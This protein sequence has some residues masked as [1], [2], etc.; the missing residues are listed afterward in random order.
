[1]TK[2]KDWGITY[3][4]TSYTRMGTKTDEEHK[5]GSVCPHFITEWLKTK[6]KKK[7]IVQELEKS[8]TIT[9][10]EGINNFFFFSHENRSWQCVP[11]VS[12]DLA[13]Q[14][15]FIAV[16]FLE[17]FAI[18]I[19]FKVQLFFKFVEKTKICTYENKIF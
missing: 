17:L 5:P 1:M 8:S 3:S 10:C 4:S 7:N 14:H 19:V 15:F 18:K 9:G 2:N 13:P 12:E 11:W 6:N 16:V